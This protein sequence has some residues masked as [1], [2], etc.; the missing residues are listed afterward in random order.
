MTPHTD[1]EVVK[2]FLGY[3]RM[4]LDRDKVLRRQGESWASEL[5]SD[6]IYDDPERCW[7]L[8]GAIAL[9]TPNE[10]ALMSL[11]F[12]LSGLFRNH[13]ELMGQVERAVRAQPQ[14]AEMMSWVVEDEQID[15]SVWARIELLSDSR[16]WVR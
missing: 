2:E 12:T 8:L 15:P 7:R 10:D 16:R 4:A 6:L 5:L 13:P 1:H 11:G 9:E 3:H 14:L